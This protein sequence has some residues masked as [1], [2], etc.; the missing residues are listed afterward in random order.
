MGVCWVVISRGRRRTWLVSSA[1]SCGGIEIRIS[2]IRHSERTR[3]NSGTR[4]LLFRCMYAQY[5]YFIVG[6]NVQSMMLLTLAMIR[7]PFK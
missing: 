3:V 6:L 7:T 2:C 4:V 1:G 5:N